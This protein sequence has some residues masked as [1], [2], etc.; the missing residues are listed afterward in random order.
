[1]ELLILSIIVFL[2]VIYLLYQEWKW[3]RYIDKIRKERMTSQT[4][5]FI[6]KE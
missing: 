1:M 6:L 4:F 5:D 2:Y 3:R